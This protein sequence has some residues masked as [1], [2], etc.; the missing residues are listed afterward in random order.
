MEN[1]IKNTDGFVKGY[2]FDECVDRCK[3]VNMITGNRIV[4]G[5]VFVWVKALGSW[6]SAFGFHFWNEDKE[7][8]VWD[9]E[10]AWETH[11]Q[12]KLKDFNYRKLNGKNFRWLKTEPFAH[13]HQFQGVIKHLNK[14][15][16]KGKGCD[17]VYVEGYGY[18]HNYELRETDWF[19][20]LLEN[21]YQ[22]FS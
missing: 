10:N 1:K 9:S 20:K 18:N 8:N 7:G 12:V 17:M 14:T 5:S 2:T 6:T 13:T 16:P 22:M 3:D 21:K 15:Y 4:G 11:P 19:M